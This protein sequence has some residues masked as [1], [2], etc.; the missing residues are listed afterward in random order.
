MPRL[1][2]NSQ[3]VGTIVPVS[4][5]PLTIAAWGLTNNATSTQTAVCITH[6]STWST[7]S[8]AL[9]WG[10][11]TATKGIRALAAS[12]GG[13]DAAET[14]TPYPVGQWAHGAAVFTSPS[15]RFAVLNG[16]FSSANT[17]LRTPTGLSQTQLGVLFNFDRFFGA[18][19]DCAI[20][21]AALTAS[22][23]NLLANGAS[24]LTVRP[25]A[26]VF[27]C[28]LFGFYT[29]ELDSISGASLTVTSAP[30]DS[31]NPPV[32]PGMFGRVL[33]PAVRSNRRLLLGI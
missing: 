23:L 17:G 10:G 4:A 12:G 13:W 32:T 31:N 25:N 8:F 28:P 7:G 20:W 15:Q 14:A 24:P 16:S 29:N 9:Q 2:N 3:I 1:F 26:L 11:G 27:Y 33:P 21:S 19:A 30:G 18:L 22:E 5:A 6:S